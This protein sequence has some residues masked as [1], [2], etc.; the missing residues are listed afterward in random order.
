MVG[1]NQQRVW[2]RNCGRPGRFLL[3]F[4]GCRYVRNRSTGLKIQYTVL[5]VSLS[6]HCSHKAIYTVCIACTLAAPYHL[7]SRPP[8]CSPNA[9]Y[10]TIHVL[11][12]ALVAH[13]SFGT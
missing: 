3:F 11:E 13:P 8:L 5:E 7:A 1:K 4:V 2:L 9:G 12:T 10:G 6:M